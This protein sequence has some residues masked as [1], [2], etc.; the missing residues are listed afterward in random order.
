MDLDFHYGVSFAMVKLNDYHKNH[1]LITMEQMDESLCAIENILTPGESSLFRHF[2][3]DITPAQ[4]ALLKE[5]IAEIRS[6]MA[7]T[8]EDLAISHREPKTNALRM[9]TTR[10]LFMELGL[11]EASASRIRGYGEIPEESGIELDRMVGVLLN[12][13]EELRKTLQNSDRTSRGMGSR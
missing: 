7:R 12:R 13:V 10:L 9:I 4:N 2:I 1:L 6:F 5:Q 8:L 11:A 3:D